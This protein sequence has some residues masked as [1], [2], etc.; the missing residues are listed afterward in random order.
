MTSKA[1]NNSII[2]FS[3]AFS[4]DLETSI[5]SPVSNWNLKNSESQSWQWD[6]KIYSLGLADETLILTVSVLILRFRFRQSWSQNSNTDRSHKINLGN[7]MVFSIFVWEISLSVLVSALFLSA[8]GDWVPSRHF[9]HFVR[10]L[11]CWLTRSCRLAL[12]TQFGKTI[13]IFS[14]ISL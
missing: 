2:I 13:Y 5:P 14:W 3:L 9:S 11:I 12:Y 6:Y 8:V 4:C 10:R 1:N 7:L